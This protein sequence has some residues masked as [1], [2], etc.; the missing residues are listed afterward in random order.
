M[1]ATASGATTM[2]V[3]VHNGQGNKVFDAANVTTPTLRLPTAHL[4]G[5]A[6]PRSRLSAAKP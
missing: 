5:R 2:Q 6:L 1:A 3:L 4:A